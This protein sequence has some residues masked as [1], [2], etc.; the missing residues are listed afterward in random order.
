M[1]LLTTLSSFF[2]ACLLTLD[3]GLREFALEG[4]PETVFNGFAGGL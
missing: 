4:Q 2:N 1:M 3:F